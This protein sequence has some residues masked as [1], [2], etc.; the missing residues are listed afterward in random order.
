M[1]VSVCFHH[2]E[3][4]QEEEEQSVCV[5]ENEIER[6]MGDKLERRN[7]WLTATRSLKLLTAIIFLGYLIVWIISP[8]NQYRNEWQSKLRA[9]TTS[10]FLG[11]QGI[12]V[13]ASAESLRP[14]SSLAFAGTNILLYTSPVL[15]I[16][17]LGC[18]YAYLKNYSSFSEENSRLL[19]IELI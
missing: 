4:R 19:A 3:R 7:S 12:W 10:S 15:V 11:P 1:V 18:I 6:E 5:R 13:A 14:S 8:T 17:L 9:K 2:Q 16:S